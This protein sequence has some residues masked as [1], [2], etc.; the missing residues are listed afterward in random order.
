MALNDLGGE[1]V[2]KL[3]I[4]V[5]SQTPTNISKATEEAEKEVGIARRDLEGAS[6]NNTFSRSRPSSTTPQRPQTKGLPF[7]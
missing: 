2:S 4:D 6:K 5:R 3:A 1:N 7:P